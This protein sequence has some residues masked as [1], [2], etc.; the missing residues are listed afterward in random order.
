M[1]EFLAWILGWD[2]TLGKVIYFPSNAIEYTIA[3]AAVARGWS[4]YLVS[5]LRSFVKSYEK[6]FL[7]LL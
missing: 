3:T 2:L 6:T 7:R 1:G 5:M 4:G